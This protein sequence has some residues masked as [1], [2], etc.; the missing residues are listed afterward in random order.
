[1]DLL[2]GAIQLTNKLKQIDHDI[3]YLKT[4]IDSHITDVGEHAHGVPQAGNSGFMPYDLYQK[5]KALFEER[6]YVTG[7]DIDD[8]EPGF[9]WGTHF[10]NKPEGADEEAI[11]MV[12]VTEYGYGRKSIRFQQAFVE[13]VWVKNIHTPN[14]AIS[15]RGWRKQLN[16]NYLWSG[17]VS[18]VGTKIE[19]SE[20]KNAYEHLMFIFEGYANNAGTVVSTSHTGVY[21]MDVINI[22]NNDDAVISATEIELDFGNSQTIAEITFNKTINVSDNS[23]AG[24]QHGVLIGILGLDL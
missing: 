21:D 5:N 12:D 22:P 9:Y 16:Y 20:D 6:K 2:K 7:V 24:S 17:S 19:L 13:S 10:S 4:K 8:L 11:S 18:K 3:R 15:T 23:D 1:M 14:N